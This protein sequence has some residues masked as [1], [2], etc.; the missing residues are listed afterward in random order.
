MGFSWILGE[1]LTLDL[2]TSNTLIYSKRKDGKV[3]EPSV[4]AVDLNNYEIVAVGEK[5]KSMEGKT[6]DNIITLAPIKGGKIVNFEIAQVMLTNLLKKAKSNFSI[7]HPKV[8]IA[9]SSGISE[10]D[11]RAIEDCVI[12]SGARSV[13]FIPSAVASAIGLG[14][15]ALDPSGNIIVNIGG[16]TVDVSLV[17]LGGVVASKFVDIGGDSVDYDIIN[18]VKNK[19]ELMIDKETAEFIKINLS[20][21][22]S[23][24]ISNN[25]SIFGRDINSGMPRNAT[26]YGKDITSS[27]FP[28]FNA[29][30]DAIKVILEKTP[31]SMTGNVLKNG[32]FITGGCSKINGCVEYLQNELRIGIN[33][34]DNPLTCTCEGA[35]VLVNTMTNK[36]NRRK[37]NE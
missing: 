33:L 21:F 19:Y 29:V 7:F 30:S 6:P 17:S 37:I 22:I 35:R 4:V 32:V 2:G 23:S 3:I 28:L 26:I 10:V 8:H 18:I 25:L 31:P 20:S 15:P 27:L 34:S 13:E 36:S 9:I 5:A 1:D 12:Y 11:R 24:N 16:G 14:L